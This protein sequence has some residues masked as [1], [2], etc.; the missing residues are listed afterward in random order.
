MSRSRQTRS[1]DEQVRDTELSCNER[2]AATPVGPSGRI[3][4]VLTGVSQARIADDTRILIALAV[5][6]LV[7]EAMP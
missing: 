4:I 5:I 3:L 1:V 6:D 2:T 7:G